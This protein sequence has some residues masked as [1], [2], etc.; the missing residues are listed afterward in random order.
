MSSLLPIVN[1]IK[2]KTRNRF[3]INFLILFKVDFLNPFKICFV[4]RKSMSDLE[5]SV[6]YE[7]PKYNND[8]RFEFNKSYSKYL[9]FI[10]NVPNMLFLN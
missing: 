8:Y 3:Y 9:F 1:N 10:K 6:Y 7:F 2:F 5:L 4:I